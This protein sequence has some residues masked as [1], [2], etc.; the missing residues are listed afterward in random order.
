MTSPSFAGSYEGTLPVEVTFTNTSTNFSN[1]FD[2]GADTTFFWNL[3]H[4]DA[5]WYY[6]DNYFEVLDTTYEDA[7]TYEICLVAVN[8]NGCTDTTCKE[9]IVYDPIIFTSVNVFTPDGDGINDVLTFEYGSLSIATFHCII[10]NSWG[11]TV[12]ELF[13]ITD[14]WDGT[15]FDGDLMSDGVYFY[16]WTATSDDGTDLEGMGSVTLLGD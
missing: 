13:D 8:K 16:T 2:P 9:L 6:T 4:D 15:D 5:A 11:T 1:P 3:N 12:A 10:V 14:S 7:G